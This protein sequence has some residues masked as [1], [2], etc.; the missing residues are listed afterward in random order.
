MLCFDTWRGPS[1]PSTH[2]LLA[3]QSGRTVQ[4]SLTLSR[5]TSLQTSGISRSVFKIYQPNQNSSFVHIDNG[6]VPV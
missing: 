5:P 3:Q 1:L 2:H 6:D 4:R